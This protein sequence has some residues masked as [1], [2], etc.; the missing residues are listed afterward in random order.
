MDI[1]RACREWVD[2]DGRVPSDVGV[3][4]RFHDCAREGMTGLEL[5]F[6][7]CAWHERRDEFCWSECAQ[8]LFDALNKEDANNSVRYHDFV[9]NLDLVCQ[10]QLGLPL[11]SVYSTQG[12]DAVAAWMRGRHERFVSFI[13]KCA[14]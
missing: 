8:F 5:L 12:V 4:P 9:Q 11:V 13:D 2:T 14:V 1:G 7:A 3:L 10:R 6:L